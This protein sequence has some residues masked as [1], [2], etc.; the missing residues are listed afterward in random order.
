MHP[1]RMDLFLIHQHAFADIFFDEPPEM[2]DMAHEI[3]CVL[4]GS[5]VARESQR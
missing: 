3:V 4:A 5:F 2:L 1:Q